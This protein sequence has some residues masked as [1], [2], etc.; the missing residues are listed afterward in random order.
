L[1]TRHVG[2]QQHPVDALHLQRNMTVDTSLLFTTLAI[3]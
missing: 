3:I 2:V 1:Q